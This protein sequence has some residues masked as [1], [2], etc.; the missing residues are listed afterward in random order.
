MEDLACDVP[1][2]HHNLAELLDPLVS[3]GLVDLEFMATQ[4]GHHEDKSHAARFFDALAQKL[5][6]RGRSELASQAK[7]IAARF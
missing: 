2:I 3:V 1:R 4:C 7:A 5:A 6:T